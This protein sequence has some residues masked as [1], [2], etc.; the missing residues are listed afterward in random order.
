MGKGR[1]LG[2]PIP[3]HALETVI[4]KNVFFKLPE[5]AVAQFNFYRL[6]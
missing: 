5:D 3:K 6:Q 2:I 4:P 1:E